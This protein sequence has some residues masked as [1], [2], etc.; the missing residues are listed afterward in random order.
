MYTQ[1]GVSANTGS[2]ERPHFPFE[3]ELAR[4]NR[5]QYCARKREGPGNPVTAVPTHVMSMGK[6]TPSADQGDTEQVKI[7]PPQVPFPFGAS[8]LI[9]KPKT[10]NVG[11]TGANQVK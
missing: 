1:N 9:G 7:E 6:P 11:G 3:P 5:R 8:L 4:C 2:P 10:E